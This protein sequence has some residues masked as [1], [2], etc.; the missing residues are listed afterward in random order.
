MTSPHVTLF[1]LFT[2]EYYFPQELEQTRMPTL[3]PFSIGSPSHSNQ[4]IKRSR[5][6][7]N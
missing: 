3:I 7:P 4:R 1:Q 2:T 5:R 6:N